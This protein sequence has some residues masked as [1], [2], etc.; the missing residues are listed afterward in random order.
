MQ[1]HFLKTSRVLKGALIDFAA[2]A[3]PKK[4]PRAW[5][6]LPDYRLLRVFS[7]QEKRGC[8][9]R[10]ALFQDS[11]GQLVVVKQLQYRLRGSAYEQL[12]HEASTLALLG[13]CEKVQA[14]TR[15]RVHFSH[16]IDYIDRDGE[17]IFIQAF[18][19]G[20]TLAEYPKGFQVEA[21][22][23]CITFLAEISEK[24]CPATM[25]L[26]PKRSNLLVALTFPLYLFGVL[27]RDW[28]KWPEFLL[29]GRMFLR[30]LNIRD[31]LAPRYVLTHRNLHTK[32]ILVDN[33][34]LTIIDLE[35]CALVDEGAE[36]PS[37]MW[38][39]TSELG[40]DHSR[41]LMN[42]FVFEAAQ[43]KKFFGLSSYHIL[44]SLLLTPR[45]SKAYEYIRSYSFIFLNE[46]AS[47]I[48]II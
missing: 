5:S 18:I 42:T 1:L 19:P 44:Q 22:H 7:E 40:V 16:F 35:T 20:R 6:D 23:E 3:L 46:I 25:A 48:G 12:W 13:G 33:G 10:V 41:I 36:L 17:T 47:G 27:L 43:K 29:F 32:N 11:K 9:F 15:H 34:V 38:I 39:Y 14:L 45:Y 31:L 2:K 28:G 37:G 21:L 30:S 24:L 8:P 4:S 26:L